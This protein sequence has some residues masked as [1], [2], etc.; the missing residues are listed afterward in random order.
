MEKKNA[1]VFK[2]KGVNIVVVSWDKEEAVKIAGK[3]G[4]AIYVESISDALQKLPEIVGKTCCKY[5]AS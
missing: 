3:R 2:A 4:H 1:I 5:P